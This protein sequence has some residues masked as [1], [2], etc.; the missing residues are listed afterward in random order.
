MSRAETAESSRVYAEIANGEGQSLSEIARTIPTSRRGG[1][2]SP[3]TVW[4]WARDGVVLPSGERLYLE[5]ARLGCRWLTS[6]AAVTRFLEAQTAAAL[7]AVR[8]VPCKPAHPEAAPSRSSNRRRR[9]I[10]AASEKLES[11]GV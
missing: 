7:G 4:R 1:R 2:C 3:A 6:S 10:D 11:M 5:V 8:A 9:E